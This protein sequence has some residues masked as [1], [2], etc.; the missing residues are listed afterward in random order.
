MVQLDP[1]DFLPLTE[2][3]FYILLSL[4][5]GNKHGYGILKDAEALSEGRVKMS[6]STLYT[7]ISRLQD[8]G[9]IARLEDGVEADS[10][11]GLPRKA[12]RLTELGWRVF[13]AE[14]GRMQAL[15]HSAQLRMKE[16]AA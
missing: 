6:T 10:G 2:T 5:E 15:I 4:A 9:M 13:E 11:P 16:D 7:A 1:G 14:T 3:T 12:Y 8:Q